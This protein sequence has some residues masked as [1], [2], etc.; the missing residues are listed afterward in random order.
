MVL[1][2]Q[3]GATSP[4]ASFPVDG[5]FGAGRNQLRKSR[6]FRRSQ[7]H[8]QILFRQ[9][10]STGKTWVTN[11]KRRPLTLRADSTNSL[12]RRVP[13]L[14]I[15]HRRCLRTVAA[16]GTAAATLW[17]TT[18]AAFASSTDAGGTTA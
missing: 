17:L 3:F 11:R 8:R 10:T 4:Q 2:K 6:Q 9:M 12:S 15:R 13:T 14:P 7:V 18:G 16:L 5:G 1:K